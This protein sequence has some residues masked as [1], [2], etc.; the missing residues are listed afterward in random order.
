[1]KYSKSVGLGNVPVA[2]LGY[3]VTCC[4]KKGQKSQLQ[5]NSKTPGQSPSTGAYCCSLGLRLPHLGN[6]GVR[7]FTW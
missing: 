6:K 7:T 5:R 1:M 4:L 3:R 2:S